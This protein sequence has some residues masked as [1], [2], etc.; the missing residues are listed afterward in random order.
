MLLKKLIKDLPKDC[1]NI[2]IKGIETNSKNVKSNYIFFAIKGNKF[3]GEKFIKQ[4]I[5][6][7]ATVVICS[8]TCT[9]KNNKIKIIKKNNLRSFLSEIVSKFYTHKPKNLIA[10]TG[11]NGKTSVSEFFFQ[12]FK[13]NKIP[14][15]SV[16]TLG[17]KFN[18]KIIKTSLTTP[19]TIELHKTLQIL[20]KKHKID[21]VIMEASSH[22]LDQSRLN[23][24]K[25]K[26][27]VFTNF[28]QDH[29]D[30]HK[31]MNSYLKAKMI[32]FQK[33]LSKNSFIISDKSK[34]KE[35]LK[36][37]KIAKTRK[38]NLLDIS[39]TI[40]HI[41]NFELNFKANF[42]FK[43]L[44][45]AILA[46]KICGLN[47]VKIFNTLKK[48]KV[49][50]GRLELIKKFTNNIKVFIDYAHTPDA[51]EE[52][53]R[54]LKKNYNSDISLVFG[55]G[56]ERDFKKR[57]LMAKI[58]RLNCHKVYVTDDNPRNETPN[59]I[60]EEIFKN[61]GNLKNKFNIGNRRKAIKKAI[62]NADPNEII[63]VAG[64]GHE[65]IQDYGKKIINISDKK[66]IKQIKVDRKRFSN[67]NHN[68]FY[69]AKIL[70][71][72]VKKKKQYNYEG[73]VIDSRDVKRG[74][75]F[76]AIK[77]KNNDGNNYISR[78]IQRGANYVV[79]SKFNKRFKHKI[80]KVKNS[81][82]FL[83]ELANLKRESSKAK[84]IS[85]TGSAGKTSLKNMLS[86]LLN[87]FDNTYCSP[88]SFNNHF[89]VPISLSNLNLGHKFGVIEVGMSKKGEIDKLTK[90]IKPHLGI[91][92]NIGEAHIENFKNLLGI[93][94][95][96]GEMIQNIN[97]GGKIILNRDDKFFNYLK[98]KAESK[99]VKVV[100]FGMTKK[101]DVHPINITKNNKANL[102][103]INLK[104][105]IIKIKTKN[106]YLYNILASLTVI[107]EL[108]LNLK[109][110]IKYFEKI[111]AFAGRGKIHEI[112]RYKKKFKL[113]DESYNAN[114]LSVKFAINN[115]SKIKKNKFKK[116][117]LL[118]DMLE[119]GD[120]SEIYHKKLSKLINNSDIDKVF[121]K[122]EKSLFTYKNLRMSKRGNIF[123]CKEDID[124]SFKNIITN[125]DYLMIKGSNATGL[126]NFAKNMIRGN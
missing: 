49:I 24:L 109:K 113:I 121:I 62:L 106:I 28:S 99:N 66:I 126:N 31:T 41:K 9:Y 89:G 79:T 120:K 1:K 101:S 43:N 52:V 10:V 122:G 86:Y 102:I 14:V 20:K 104:G 125:N 7:G 74:N 3:N 38:L 71:K 100:S 111:E 108:G 72:V 58:A 34:K 39:K 16:G 85:I 83:R 50:E 23:N 90:M 103:K 117:L 112:N 115:F 124:N 8:K 95:A 94:D 18:N 91:I 70:S 45:M 84:I 81:I 56:G 92:T 4:A 77:G 36:L 29:L 73:V 44:S 12:I 61:L 32:L 22:G 5:F 67:K 60:R 57:P 33:L 55:C 26:A 27:G 98:Q 25:F 80:I 54:S 13:F 63:L 65:N 87:V 82:T 75:L 15:A 107:E 105:K 19:N 51:L 97:K 42:Q 53:L 68:L 35:F 30:Y 6:K 21:N 96:K 69:N 59:K 2:K 93:A 123:Q 78:A 11:T 119:L 110:I 17:I 114:P 64:K 88:K 37:K 48:I 40:D 118:G 46:A 47:N 116:Y 76:I